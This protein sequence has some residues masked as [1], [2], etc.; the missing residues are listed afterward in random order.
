[1][2]FDDFILWYACVPFLL[3]FMC[4]LLVFVYFWICWVFVAVH[5]LSPVVTRGGYSL[6]AVL[7]PL[8]AVVSLVAELRLYSMKT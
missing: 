2:C 3:V 7:R 8:F 6:V 1:M 4:I 5:G